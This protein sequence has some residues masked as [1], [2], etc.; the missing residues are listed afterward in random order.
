MSLSVR[1]SIRWLP[2]PNASE[3]TYTAVLTSPGRRF[4]DI[5]I[6][7][8]PITGELGTTI[9]WAF[10]GVSSS[11]TRDGVRHCTWRHVVDSRTRTPEAVVDEGDVFPLDGG[12][13]LETG[14]MVNPATGQLTNYEEVWD[15]LEAKAIIPEGSTQQLRAYCVVLELEDEERE[16]RGMVVYLGRHCHGVVRAGPRFTAEM[17]TWE[18]ATGWQ[19]KFQAGDLSIPGPGHIHGNP[20][21][22]TEQQ[23][24][25]E[26]TFSRWRVVE[27]AYS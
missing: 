12:R 27:T 22:D 8:D 3:P 13:T 11:E 6:V 24:R 4:V 25:L 15:D 14:R 2:D 9:D 26:D 18:N 23:I 5:R 21:S 20:Q 7:K 17:W 10:A 16:E 1:D 19:R